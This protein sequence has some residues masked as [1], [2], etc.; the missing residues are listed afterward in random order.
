MCLVEPSQVVSQSAKMAN[1]GEEE[2]YGSNESVE[3]DA[4]G[5]P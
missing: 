1:C 2:D 3:I 4:K 5:R